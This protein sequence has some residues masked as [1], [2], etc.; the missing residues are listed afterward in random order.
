MKKIIGIKNQVRITTILFFHLI[1]R[2][3]KVK[4][5]HEITLFM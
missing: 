2:L 1:L 5:K 3:S 4:K